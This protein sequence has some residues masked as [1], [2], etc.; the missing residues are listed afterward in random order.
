MI[1]LIYISQTRDCIST[2]VSISHGPTTT[3]S[4]LIP[5]NASIRLPILPQT[6]MLRGLV[7]IYNKS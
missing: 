2:T 6:A 7:V 4:L 3:H 5:L 1:W